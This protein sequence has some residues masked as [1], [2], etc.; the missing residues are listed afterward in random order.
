M[1]SLEECI[2]TILPI[3]IKQALYGINLIY[4]RGESLSMESFFSIFPYFV[5]TGTCRSTA[6]VYKP[7]LL[8]AVPGILWLS[9]LG[10]LQKPFCCVLL[11]GG[12]SLEC[13]EPNLHTFR[14]DSGFKG[15]EMFKQR[16]SAPTVYPIFS[17]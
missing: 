12:R 10:K 13:S 5:A 1:A 16:L 8:F 4:V 6:T 17:V 15:T 7:C 3:W 9:P 11:K 14:M 2:D